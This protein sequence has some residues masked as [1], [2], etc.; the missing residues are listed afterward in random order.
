MEA[1]PFYRWIRDTYVWHVV[2]QFAALYALGGL[3]AVVWGGALR[4][5]WVYHITWFVNSASHVWG[6]QDYATGDQSRNNW[7]VAILAFGEG[8]HNNHHAFEYA[9][10]HGMDHWWQVD[11]TWYVIWALQKLGL[12]TNV[13]MPTDKQKERLRISKPAAAAA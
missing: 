5:C 12:A 11:V 9:A 3:G 1:Q 2:A 7:W 13:K 10:R 8:W 4:M 6:Y